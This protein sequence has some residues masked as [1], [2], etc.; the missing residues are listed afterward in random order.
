MGSCLSYFCKKKN[1]NYEY[2]NNESFN[3]PLTNI[4]SFNTPLTH[5]K[6]QQD[7]YPVYNKIIPNNIFQHRI[8]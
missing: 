4:N 6:I 2:Y 8:I 5:I 1:N 7:E 3:T